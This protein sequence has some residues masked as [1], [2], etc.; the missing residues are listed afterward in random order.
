MCRYT[1]TLNAQLFP[2]IHYLQKVHFS[3]LII[4]ILKSILFVYGILDLII[5][6]PGGSRV[7]DSTS[8]FFFY[9]YLVEVLYD[10]TCVLEFV[11]DD[12]STADVKHMI[13]KFQN[14]SVIFIFSYVYCFCACEQ[15]RNFDYILK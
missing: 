8:G 14:A 3:E 6:R 11:G 9:F 15:D 4:F 10:I 5:T 13:W 7:E 2:Q 12:I 1:Q